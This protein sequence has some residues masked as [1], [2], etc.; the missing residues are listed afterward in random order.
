MSELVE[1]LADLTAL[2]DREALD[3]SLVSAIN[4][5]VH[6]QTVAICRVVGDTENER[7]LTT[8]QMGADQVTPTSDSAWSHLDLLPKLAA[9]PLRE[10]AVSLRQVM[11]SD[12]AAPEQIKTMDMD[13]RDPVW[14]QETQKAAPTPQNGEAHK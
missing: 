1:K 2:R 6:P 14:W 7:W 11:H 10:Q 9:Y 4:D 3:I 12:G 8:A 5:L 13:C